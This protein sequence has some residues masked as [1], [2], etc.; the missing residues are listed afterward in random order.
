MTVDST[1]AKFK[2]LRHNVQGFTNNQLELTVL[3]NTKLQDLDVTCLTE[4]WLT[5][6]QI[7]II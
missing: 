7:S 2:I 4:H 1:H 6:V 3:L 5:E